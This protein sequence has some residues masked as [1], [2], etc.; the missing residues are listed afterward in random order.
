MTRVHHGGKEHLSVL[1]TGFVGPVREGLMV[2]FTT[3]YSHMRD[4]DRTIV[5]DEGH[6]P[7][8]THES[9]VAYRRAEIIREGDLKRREESGLLRWVEPFPQSMVQSILDGV[10][11]SRHTKRFILEFLDEHGF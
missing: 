2:N 10:R 9:I 1:L 3:L 5:A 11:T 4:P 7:L 8:I 6:H